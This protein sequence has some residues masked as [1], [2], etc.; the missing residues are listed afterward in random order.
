MPTI[1]NIST[2]KRQ[3]EGDSKNTVESGEEYEQDNPKI[4]GT[5]TN[6]YKSK[7]ENKEILVNRASRLG[8]KGKEL[9]ENNNDEEQKA[10]YAKGKKQYDDDSEWESDEHIADRVDRGGNES[11]TSRTP[12]IN[13]YP[14]KLKNM[15]K[16]KRTV[17][18]DNNYGRGGK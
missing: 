3:L 9:S 10:A 16:I 7:E 5:T 1:K 13:P 15:E 12:S 18:S 6:I 8:Q 14:S 11:Y 17:M 4:S 2:K